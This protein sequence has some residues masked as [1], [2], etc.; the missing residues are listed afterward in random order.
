[1]MLRWTVT[2]LTAL[3]AFG[4]AA[5]AE[6][7]T[8]S[9]FNTERGGR[10]VVLAEQQL[11]M[12]DRAV[13]DGGGEALFIYLSAAQKQHLGADLISVCALH[14]SYPFSRAVAIAYAEEAI[15]HHMG[16]D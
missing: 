10:F 5:M 4:Q 15:A 11:L 12:M 6:S 9:E 16:G 2:L 3:C 14:P 1:M 13:I 8:C 7:P